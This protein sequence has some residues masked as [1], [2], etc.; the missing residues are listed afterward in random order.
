MAKRRGWIFGIVVACCAIVPA[1]A[2]EPRLQDVLA[3]VTLDL[4][5]DGAFSRALLVQGTDDSASLMIY[6]SSDA[7]RDAPMKL[8]LD[9]KDFAFAG[10][11]WGQ[12]PSLSVGA[13]GSL[14]VTSGNSGVGRNHW[15]QKVTIVRRNNDFIVAG[16]TLDSFDTLDPKASHHCDV[17]MLSGTAIRDDRTTKGPPR[18]LRVADW[19]DEALPRECRF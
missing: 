13:K 11:I 4:T 17:N 15:E 7:S 14:V 19:S 3:V 18:P 1:L 6:L 9:K 2:A 10:A 16:V 8:A 5:D 12:M